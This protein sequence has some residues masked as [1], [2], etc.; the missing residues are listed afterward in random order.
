MANPHLQQANLARDL[1]ADMGQKVADASQEGVAEDETKVVDEIESLCMNC[2]ADV[3]AHSCESRRGCT[4]S[5]RA[6]PDSSS[7]EYLFSAKL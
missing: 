1:F 7:R 3:S 4:D 2:H 6:L 5:Y